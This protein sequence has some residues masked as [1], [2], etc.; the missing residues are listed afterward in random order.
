MTGIGRKSRTGCKN[1]V[2]NGS[3]EYVIQA[4]EEKIS[5]AD[6]RN[7]SKRTE[8][9]KTPWGMFSRIL[10][11]KKNPNVRIILCASYDRAEAIIDKCTDMGNKAALKSLFNYDVKIKP[12]TVSDIN[13]EL[14]GKLGRRLTLT[15][16]FKEQ[17]AAINEAIYHGSTLRG[18]DYVDDMYNKIIKEKYCG[19]TKQGMLTEDIIPSLKALTALTPSRETSLAALNSLTGLTNVKKLLK[20]LEGFCRL[21]PERAKEMYLN[22]VFT[23]N[24]GTGKT[25]VAYMMADILCSLGVIKNRK[26]VEITLF[27]ICTHFKMPSFPIKFDMEINIFFDCFNN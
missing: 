21:N 22:F 11:E 14:I 7:K 10:L 1:M 6:I 2:Y 27:I 12:A 9:A 18:T 4:W 15:P 26:V 19:R 17:L 3:S 20:E 8:A 25:T 23:G 24:P 5:P 16:E 13:A